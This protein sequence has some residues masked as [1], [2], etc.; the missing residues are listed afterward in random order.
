M[1]LVLKVLSWLIVNYFKVFV[2]IVKNIIVISMLIFGCCLSDINFN[3]LFVLGYWVDMVCDEDDM[4]LF[5]L[6]C[7][8]EE[9]EGIV[10]DKVGV[11][12]W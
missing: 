10:E 2:K 5:Y 1:G 6:F 3:L 11:N 9:D 8:E 7:L 12:K 4:I